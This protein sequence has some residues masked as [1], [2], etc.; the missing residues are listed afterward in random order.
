[1]QVI[2]KEGER[3]IQTTIT[4]GYADFTGEYIPGKGMG[5]NLTV[6]EYLATL[7]DGYAVW[8]LETASDKIDQVQAAQ[9]IGPWEEITKKEYWN[10]L[11][12]FPPEKWL[13]AGGVNIFRLMEYTAGNITQH[14]AKIAGR[15]FQANRRTTDSY[16]TMADEIK[17]MIN[18]EVPQ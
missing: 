4:N 9:Y 18:A 14:F 7:P 5:E 15:Y 2:Y 16:E 8:D 12:M 3:N 10:F 6:A 11:E 13:T 1:M 17:Q